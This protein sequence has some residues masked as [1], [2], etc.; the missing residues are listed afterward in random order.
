V[1]VPVSW[2]EVNAKLDP[3][4]F[5]IDSVRARLRSLK[6]DPWRD[7]F[8]VKQGIGQL[9]APA[10]AEDEPPRKRRRSTRG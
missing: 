1:A 7:F 3:A 10:A 4:G 2:D 6:R 8:T 9:A 5:D